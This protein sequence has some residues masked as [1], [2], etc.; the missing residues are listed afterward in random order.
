[1]AGCVRLDGRLTMN[2]QATRL[3]R[4]ASTA[5]IWPLVGMLGGLFVGGLRAWGSG[6]HEFAQ[7]G[8]VIRWSVTG[9]FMGLALVILLALP[10]YRQDKLTIRRTMAVFVVAGVLTW[11]FTRILSEAIG[12]EGF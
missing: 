11:F 4:N 7:I 5:V 8:C 1:M 6:L 3:V 9:F 12:F 2:Q 10:I